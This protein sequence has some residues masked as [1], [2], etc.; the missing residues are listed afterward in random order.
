MSVKQT[1]GDD[2]EVERARRSRL[3]WTISSS[4]PLRFAYSPPLQTRALSSHIISLPIL[5]P[6]PFIEAFQQRRKLSSTMALSSRLLS[7]SK[8]VCP[9]PPWIGSV[10]PTFHSL[11][12][13]MFD[14]YEWCDN[15][16]LF[17]FF[18]FLFR[19]G[20]CYCR[21]LLWILTM[22]KSLTISLPRNSIFNSF[23]F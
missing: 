17:S 2:L 20:A 11:W 19:T 3:H 21:I 6:F 23:L 7:K 16:F 10:Y 15:R 12:F 1:N 14:V 4:L 8:Q 5:N 13:F 22:V 18:R 9:F